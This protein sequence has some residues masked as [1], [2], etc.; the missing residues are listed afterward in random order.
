[1]RSSLRGIYRTVRRNGYLHFCFAH[2]VLEYP[3]IVQSGELLLIRQSPAPAF[4]EGS[5]QRW[6]YLLGTR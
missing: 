6:P 5:G 3:S 1:M 2:A 4:P